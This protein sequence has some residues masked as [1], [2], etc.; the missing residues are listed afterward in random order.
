MDGEY[1]GYL[2]TCAGFWIFDRFLRLV[3]IGVLNYRV[4][5]SGKNDPLKRSQATATYDADG[6]IIRLT[7]RP[8]VNLLVGAGIHYYIYTPTSSGFRLWENH[9]FTLGSW[10]GVPAA[11]ADD[12]P[13]HESALPASGPTSPVSA[14]SKSD[15]K[16]ISSGGR[17]VELHPTQQELMFLVRPYK[18]MTNTLKKQLLKAPGHTKDM[19]VLIEGPYGSPA[20]LRQYERVL[21]ISGGSGVTGILAYLYEFEQHARAG[22]AAGRTMRFVWAARE[23]AFVADVVSKDLGA[24]VARADTRLDF[25]MTRG[26]KTAPGLVESALERAGRASGSSIDTEKSEKAPVGG[27]VYE[28]RPDLAALL[29][30]EISQL[31]GDT[32]RLAVVVCGPGRLADDVRYEVVKA[33]GSKIDASRIELHEESFGW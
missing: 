4:F 8:S 2:W 31:V 3:R 20:D 13:A 10:Y 21:M 16:S 29:D 9:P 28:G 32:G 15:S 17:D 22:K 25:Y 5:I 26:T 23:P 19:R 12:T 1:D 7:V 27:G 11:R 24:F 6:D 14:D 30:E 18:G 33:I